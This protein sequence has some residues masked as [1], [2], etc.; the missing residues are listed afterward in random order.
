M[1]NKSKKKI[2]KTIN[3]ILILTLIL[4]ISM[5]IFMRIEVQAENI[6][7]E[8]GTQE[9]PWDISGDGRVIAVLSKSGV[10]TISGNGRMKDWSG[11]NSSTWHDLTDSSKINKI[12]IEKGITNVGK[13]AFWGLGNLVSVEI[14]DTVTNIGEEA[15]SNCK[16]LSNI[17]V[18]K[19]NQNYIS[20]NGILFN[21]NRT[22]IIIYPSGKK[23]EEYV[24]PSTV[25]KIKKQAFSRNNLRSIKMQDGIET[26]EKSAFEYSKLLETIYIVDTVKDIDS[27]AFSYCKKLKNVHIPKGIRY[28]AQYMFDSCVSLESIDIPSNIKI[29]R[30]DAFKGCI[31]LK[32]INV[33]LENQYY[34]SENGI[35]FNKDKTKIEIYP[36]GIENREYQVPDTISK[37]GDYAFK[38]NKYL[39]KIVLT[40]KV[41]LIGRESFGNM[42]NLK[43]I[44]IPDSVTSIDLDAFKGCKE[45]ID[46][47]LPD[48]VNKYGGNILDDA[49]LNYIVDMNTTT[50]TI[51]IDMPKI[52][53][54]VKSVGDILYTDKNLILN[55]CSISEDGNK[56]IIEKSTIQ[57]G[58][59]VNIKVVGSDNLGDVTIFILPNRIDVSVRQDN[60]VIARFN[61]GVVTINGNGAIKEGTSQSNTRWHG[62]WNKASI[63]T[64]IITKGITKIGMDEFNG[65]ENLVDVEI[66]NTIQ[67]IE[68]SAFNRC[69][70]LESIELSSS[71]NSIENY[72]FNNCNKLKNIDV[73]INNK[74]FCSENGIL[75]TKDKR[76]LI[77]YPDGKEELNYKIPDFVTII[78]H[79]AI[80]NDN[81]VAVEIGNNVNAIETNGISGCI[82]LN[83]VS[84]PVEVV[85]IKE[86]NFAYCENLQNIN[87]DTNNSNYSSEN[88]VLFTKDKTKIIK[89][90]SGKNNAEYIIP[91]SV[92]TIGEYCFENAKELKNVK[93]TSN[94]LNIEYSAFSQSGLD[95]IT[96]PSNVQNIS[97]YSLS[98]CD[99]LSK[100]VFLNNN[101]TIEDTA[102]SHSSNVVIYCR[103]NSDMIQEYARNCNIVYILDENPPLVQ[104]IPEGNLEV[105]K[106]Q[107]FTVN[108]NDNNEVGVNKDKIKYQWT[109]SIE[110]PT[111]ASFKA[112]LENGQTLT[113]KD[114]D[115][116]WYLWVYAEDLLENT[117]ITRSDEFLLDNTTPDINI[118]YNTKKP[119]NQNVIATITANEEIQEVEGWKISTNKKELT[120]EYS[121]NIEETI[122]VKDLAGNISTVKVT[123]KNI[124]NTVPTANVDY[125][126]LLPTNQ[127]VVAIITVNE[128]IQE[129]E[130]WKLSEDKKELTKEYL[131]NAEE[132][133]TI[134]DLVGNEATV[135]VKINNIDKETPQITVNY[136]TEKPVNGIVTV[137]IISNEEIQEIDGWKL[138]EDKRKL[139][140]EYSK[141]TEETVTV[142]D[143][144][145]NKT[146]VK[147]N[148]KNI[149]HTL[150][151]IKIG[152]ISKDQNIDIT[153]IILLKRH[154]I[155][156][157]KTKW[158]LTGDS[159]KAADI[160]QNGQ[161]DISDLLLLKRQVIK[162]FYVV[163]H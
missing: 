41:T 155:A 99:D 1:K 97:E 30:S 23:E 33:N 48:T 131:K 116:K 32:S 122:S 36:E 4:Q 42:K 158:K 154:L 72:A 100:V 104:I 79:S 73:N 55:N 133:I 107:S 124:D 43:D 147:I 31:K 83:T 89:Y 142:K 146:Q 49:I 62:G 46:F 84:I 82:N 70:S 22:E 53:K 69:R 57:Q 140:K 56:I 109:Q 162:K 61:N 129:V 152:D 9:N 85:K 159:L 52:L 120:K 156:G 108:V 126:I 6:V 128:E 92:I 141:N 103:Q 19:E 161:V 50:Q 123:I 17:N 21:K 29:I 38:E 25:K 136:S 127:N 77:K 11:G 81:L 44:K 157:N 27:W 75:F 68:Y 63:D 135:K 66:A 80:N 37:I 143:L 76:T 60:S 118:K 28:L 137:N 134:K 132:E 20:E 13:Y 54:K 91:Q 101:V 110:E 12:I 96:I 98:Y 59:Y 153:D 26:I 88:G 95:N 24:I 125:S 39:R 90:P 115:G 105:S 58:K 94:V 130:G 15:F 150:P 10:L 149:D 5:P 112:T 138:S 71:V 114:G 74:T 16:D 117:I 119:T 151:V 93:I 8:N 121:Q 40:D 102:F 113:K 106:T 51:E 145:G 45:L 2:R 47:E 86:G 144:V 67:E 64:V 65:F 14:S 78:G 160:N 35:L 7:T 87:V 111:E 163:N 139:T 148:V 3:T 18:S 34:S